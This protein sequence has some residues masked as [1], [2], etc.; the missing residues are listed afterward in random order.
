MGKIIAIGGGYQ[1]GNFDCQLEKII[2]NLIKKEKPK[3]IFIPYGSN[4]FEE[5]YNEFKHIYETLGCHVNLLQPGDE[6]LLHQADL[7]YLGRG[8]TIP[9]VE[10]LRETNII[11]LLF[12]ASENGAIIAGFSAGAHALF[13]LAGSN[14]KDIGYT[15]VEGIGMVEGCMMSHYN[16]T[17]RA[18]AFHKLLSKRRLAGIGLE[19]HTMVVVEDNVASF[20]SSK[21]GS[22][23]YL[24]KTVNFQEPIRI[25]P[26]EKIQ[27]P[28]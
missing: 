8:E 7:I 26:D 20:Y 11:P 12:Q 21:A 19:D 24:I 2:R 6:H 13:T 27:L 14:E 10:T 5:N 23:V 28:L 18:E 3:V 9:L 16:Y 4:D 22:S 15:I 25:M 17:E 1:G